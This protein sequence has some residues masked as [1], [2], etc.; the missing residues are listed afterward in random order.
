MTSAPVRL[1]ILGTGSWAASHAEEFSRLPTC[2][3]VAGVDANETRARDF[4]ALH[5]IPNAFTDLDAAIAW[6]EFDAVAN[7]TPDGAHHPTT[8]KLIAAGKHV[9]C[10][11]P[12][13]QSYPLAVEMTEAMGAARLVGMVNLTYRNVPALQQARAMIAAGDIGE[14][15]HLEASYRQSWLVGKHWGD[16]KKE[17]RWLWRLSSAHGSRGVLGDVG[18][19]ILDFATWAIGLEPVSVQA[20]LHT[21]KKAKGDKIGA[22]AL[23]ANDSAVMS[24]TFANGALGVV[25]ASR[26][27]TGYGNT[28]RLQVYGT[29]GALELE[30]GSAT[31]L[32]RACDGANVDDLAWREVHCPPVP[33]NQA[34]FIAAVLA[35]KTDEPSFQRAAD[36]QRVL[37]ACFTAEAQRSVALL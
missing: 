21:F 18:I 28:L 6:G 22:Y 9:F 5:A 13:A 29:K 8:M 32:L 20:R 31:T 30:H 16:W 1:L 25:Q 10:E 14:V 11:K 3:V 27:F 24:L 17:E 26:Y 37:D 34:R 23:D 35:G 12:L 36:L 7:V 4:C 19:H 2:R 15:R 33:V